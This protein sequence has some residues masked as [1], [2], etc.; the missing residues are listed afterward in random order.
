MR[1]PPRLLPFVLSLATLA[2]PAPAARAQ[3]DRLTFP[4]LDWRA[5]ETPHF[6]IYYPAGAEA[7]TRDLA[8]RIESVYRDVSR[9]V[10]SAPDRRVTVIVE[11]PYAVPNGFA[12]PLL[13]EPVVF[14]W[15][16]PPEPASGVADSRGWGEMLAVHELTHIAQLTRP[17][18]NPLQRLLTRFSPAKLG[19]LAVK[20]PRWLIEGYATYVEGKLTGMGRPH[21][22]WRA[23][24]LREWARE[25]KLPTYGQLSHD[26]RFEGGSMAYLVGSAYLQWLVDRAGDSSLVHLW[27]R[28]SARS[29]R[30]FDDAF[31]GVYGGA[32][33]D[34]YGRFTA[35]LTGR[36]LDVERAIRSAIAP[37]ADSGAGRVV[38]ALSWRTGSPAVSRDG[39]FVALTLSP[40]DE[41]TRVVVW[42]TAEPP[43][44]TAAARARERARRL[45]PEDVPA[46]EWRPRPREPV[47]TLWPTGGAAYTEPRFLPDGRH[48]LVIRS[49]GRGDGAVRPDL[50][51]WDRRTGAVRRITHGGGI[52]HADPSPDGTWAVADRCVEGICDVVRVDLATGRLTTLAHGAPRVVY[53]RPRVSPDGRT[54]A[55]ALQ[56]GGCWRIALL[57]AAGPSAPRPIGPDDGANR[58]DPAFFPDGR[59][60]ALVSDATGIPN[61]EVMDASTGAVRALTFV[62]GAALAPEPDSAGGVVYYLRLH[63][64]GLD[65]NAVP[66]TV[67]RTTTLALSPELAPAV[68][69]PP[70]PPGPFAAGA[71]PESR[72]YGIGPRTYRVLPS[73]VWGAEG[74]SVG[75]M[76]AG[77]DPVGR[78]TWVAQG[79]YG[80]RGTWRG[81]SAGAAWRGWPPVLSAEGFYVEDHPSA[82]HGDVSTPLALDADYAG[83]AAR[84]EWD[85]DRLTSAYAI[86]VGGSA[87][88]IDGPARAGAA[89]S[90]AF[91]EWRGAF[92]QTP[93]TWAIIE[94][95]SLAG[96][97]GRT[98]GDGWS[99]G[100]ATG[101]LSLR[102]PRIDIDAEG[103]YGIVSSG[104]D[105]FEQFTIGGSRPPLFDPSL[106]AQRV[107]MPALPVGVAGGRSMAFWRVT[108]PRSP[109]SPYFWSAS[110]GDTPR[111]WHHVVGVEGAFHTDGLWPVRLPGVRVLGGIGYS[112]SRPFAHETRAYLSITYRP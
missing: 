24:V 36:A 58:Y 8:S 92:R 82:Q 84:L 20:S 78:L 31:A 49:T 99:R 77:L 63:A 30:P 23:A 105:P 96:A 60:L 106:L 26:A 2:A 80:D 64:K 56:R 48:L 70:D 104:A 18:R 28:M 33:Q 55:V 72:A 100:I 12:I 38:Q 83:G 53:D 14:F 43:V 88:R 40:R 79:M 76:L 44:D 10:G 11:D 17:S 9:I 107:A 7:W 74:K 93:R 108:L 1:L 37:A 103:G 42:R 47:A 86:A 4:E 110:A 46:I 19:P 52:Q 16:T 71:V 61:V 32:P 13:D 66:D 54:I 39:R 97:A 15:P 34:L 68:R 25:G 59:A 41:P 90:L 3:T 75:A 51:I 5:I 73:L 50:F 35:E 91:A 81:A 109:L 21:S 62:T 85:I 27:R 101:T 102:T 22:A 65:L 95:I 98:A 94:R 45:D 69:V 89:R 111:R 6:H 29:D 112:L 57:D 67:T 87:G